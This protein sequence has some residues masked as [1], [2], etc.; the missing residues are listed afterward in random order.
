MG[1][2]YWRGGRHGLDYNALEGKMELIKHNY[3]V[4]AII[5]FIYGVVMSILNTPFSAL[6]WFVTLVM[7]GVFDVVFNFAFMHRRLKE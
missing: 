3:F 7:I 1:V 6:T 5:F 2:A 4:Q